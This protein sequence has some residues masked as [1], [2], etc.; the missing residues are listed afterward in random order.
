MVELVPTT[1][2]FVIKYYPCRH[3]LE[4]ITDIISVG[5]GKLVFLPP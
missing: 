2:A 1:L 4:T 5:S 3:I